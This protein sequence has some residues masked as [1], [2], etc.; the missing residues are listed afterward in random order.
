MSQTPRHYVALG[1]SYTAAPL[2]PVTDIANGCF[3]SDNN[4]P[5]LT[6]RKLGA[7]L[8]DRS[9]GGARTID[10]SKAQ[11]PDV[12]AQL[13]ALS[14]AVDLVTIGLGGNDQGLFQQL[15]NQCP[16][17]RAQDPKG[18]PCQAAMTAGG[19][20]KL[21][22]ILKSTG[23]KLTSSLRQVHA[24]APKAQVIVVGY[25]EI[26]AAGKVCD[27]LPLAAGDYAYAAKV[28]KALT[29]M[30]RDAAA[31]S[32]SAYVDIFKASLGHDVCSADPWVNGSV[33][34]Q[35]RAAAYHPFAVEQK[36]VSGLVLAAI[37]D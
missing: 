34:D 2:V 26:V 9:C 23:R 15:I 20:D 31:S 17:L 10:L 37:K 5:S 30:V 22:T 33:N 19:G 29:N 24:K 13:S 3:R 21:L 6:A 8:D 28:N 18:A 32:D 4:Y 16:R 25:P 11:H 27:Q 7:Q 36:A 12:P 35:R 14:P 1:D